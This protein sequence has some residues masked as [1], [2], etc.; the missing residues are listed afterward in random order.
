MVTGHRDLT[1]FSFF[2]QIKI[3]TI[4]IYRGSLK[5]AN[6]DFLNTSKHWCLSKKHL[7]LH[8][9]FLSFL[10]RGAGITFQAGVSIFRM[11][12]SFISSFSRLAVILSE[13]NG[14]ERMK[15]FH[16]S[17]SLRVRRLKWCWFVGLYLAWLQ[18]AL[19]MVAMERQEWMQCS[20]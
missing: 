20:K 11:A 13:L 14:T 7:Y 17:V 19:S 18:L 1:G 8:F 12:V 3:L 16:S 15:S 9:H 2:Q 10:H 6:I 4:G 5:M